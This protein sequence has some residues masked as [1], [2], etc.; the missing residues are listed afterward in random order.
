MFTI[1]P[2][3]FSIETIVIFTSIWSNQPIKLITLTCLNLMDHVIKLVEHM[4]KP[5]VSSNIP[6]KLVHV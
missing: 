2:R 4:S 6:I 1:E 3:L 5:F